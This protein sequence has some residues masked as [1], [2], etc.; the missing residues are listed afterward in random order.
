MPPSML[1]MFYH[2]P[3]DSS[4]ELSL[5]TVKFFMKLMLQRKESDVNI[6]DP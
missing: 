4:L 1:L 3:N 5:S 2:F 6:R